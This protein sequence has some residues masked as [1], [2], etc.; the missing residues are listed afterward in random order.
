MSTWGYDQIWCIW[1]T[2]AL[3]I[4][5]SYASGNPNE[6]QSLAEFALIREEGPR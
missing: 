1:M 6:Y 2:L 5:H 4:Y 3:G